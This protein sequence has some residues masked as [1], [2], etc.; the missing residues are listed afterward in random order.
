MLPVNLNSCI[1][2]SLV[3]VVVSI[4]DLHDDPGVIDRG[5]KLKY[6]YHRQWTGNSSQQTRRQNEGNRQS[7]CVI[8]S[9]LLEL[10]IEFW[11]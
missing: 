5:L 8:I 3:L 9:V 7:L 11:E 6:P 10:V 2:G 1:Y 4:L